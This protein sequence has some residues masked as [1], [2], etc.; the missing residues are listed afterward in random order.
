RAT[1]NQ[2]GVFD[3]EAQYFRQHRWVPSPG[4]PIFSGDTLKILGDKKTPEDSLLIGHVIGTDIPIFL[5]YSSACEG[6]VA[7]LGMTK[8]GKST[9][10][11]KIATD[12]SA[13]RRVTILDQ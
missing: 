6:H 3:E 13:T 11:A 10:A 9:L 12:L 5:N 8:M 2:L 7:I 4:G 1:G